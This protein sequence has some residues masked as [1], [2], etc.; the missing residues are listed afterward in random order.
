VE[1]SY[2]EKDNIHSIIEK[3]SNKPDIRL[4]IVP[5][6]T[7]SPASLPVIDA[8]DSSNSEKD[9]YQDQLGSYLELP[10]HSYKFHSNSTDP[11][12]A[13]QSN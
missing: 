4:P 6:G 11:N 13:I 12:V 8:K 10:F 9:E 5:E 1:H 7:N 3:S 2:K